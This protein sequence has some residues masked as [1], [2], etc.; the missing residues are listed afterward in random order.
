MSDMDTDKTITSKKIRT[1]C[2]QCFNNC[3]AVAHVENGKFTKVTPDKAHK[4]YR[5]LC[6]K[7]LAGP[8]MVYNSARLEYPLK[9]TNPKGADNPGWKRISWEEALD[10]VADKMQT[11][12]DRHGAEA[13]VFSQTNASAPLWE[14]SSF[15]RRLSNIYG[16]PNHMTTTHICNWHRDNGSALTFGKPGDDFAA[17]WPDFKNSKTILIWGNNPKATM[18][19]FNWQIKAAKKNGARVIA[20]DPRLTDF[21]ARADIWLQVK[22]GTDG[23]LALGMI[24]LMLKHKLYDDGFVRNWTNAPLLVR[25][26][27]GDLLRVSMVEPSETNRDMFYVVDEANKTPV[28]LTPGSKLDCSPCLEW[29]GDIK[30]AGDKPVGCKTVFSLLKEAVAIYTPGFVQAHTSVSGELLEKTVRM[31]AKNGPS[32]WFSF[33]GVEQNLNATQTNRAICTFYAL[34]GDYDKKG[35]NAVHSLVPPLAFPF[36]FE[37]VTPEMFKK[38]IALS[39]HPLGPAG[40]IMSVPHYLICK[41]IEEADPY[42][43]KGLIVFGANTVSALPDSKM[44]ANALK[45]LDFHVH[46]DLTLNPTAALADIVL[47]S[48]TFWETG[49]IG[50]PLEFQG[51]KWVL[52]WREPA[53]APRGES[54]D[55]LWIIFELAKRLGYSDKFWNGNLDTAF[56]SMLEPLKIKLRD[57]KSADGGIFIQRPF[58]Y[59]KYK[60]SGFGNMSGRVEL[61]SQHLKEIEQAPIPEWKN[62]YDIFRKAGIDK[63]EYPFILINSKLRGYCQSQHRAIPSLRKQNPHPFLEINQK[64]AKEMG[65][66]QGETVILET[67]HGKITLEARLGD[68]IA[69][70]V[71]CTQHGWWQACPELGLPG[72]DIYSSKGPNVNLL[73][74]ND[75]V[76]PISGSVHMRGFP[77]NIKKH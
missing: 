70:D 10:T 1:Y 18:N 65:I 33:N 68:G 24:H 27:T 53:A 17:G 67:V 74:K 64:K 14:I 59:Q 2:A 57:L 21:A 19:A 39:A 30:M 35:G 62:P 43:V 31:V 20:V 66:V 60:K 9:R 48:T 12:K 22:P 29:N 26:D 77:C 63:S 69:P 76:D 16:T 15:I 45:K 71:V 5:P 51:N 36:G 47:P 73:Y 37:F 38:N 7:G 13:F 49:R 52:Q 42:P 23:A 40:T 3:P 50:Y 11:I 58:E 8:E 4:F 72:H 61:F 54:K 56:E 32:C 6:P 28:S 34:T 25:N 75:F 46:I 41:A 44:T 55:E